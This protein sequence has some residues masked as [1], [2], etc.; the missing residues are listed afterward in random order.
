MLWNSAMT[1][2][3][4]YGQLTICCHY[5]SILFTYTVGCVSMPAT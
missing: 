3:K 5:I 1:I 2:L 4:N